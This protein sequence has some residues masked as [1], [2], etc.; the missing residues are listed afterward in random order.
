MSVTAASF[1]EPLRLHSCRAVSCSTV[2]SSAF[3]GDFQQRK[4]C[5]IHYF[6]RPAISLYLG[7][8]YNN[9]YIFL[10]LIYTG[11]TPNRPGGL[12]NATKPLSGGLPKGYRPCLR[13]RTRLRKKVKIVS[14]RIYSP[15]TSQSRTAK[16]V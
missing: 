2:I 12:A 6:L 3:F 4:C 11:T 14:L 5:K 10:F 8:F 7:C 15:D 9:K 1:V 13:G 16:K